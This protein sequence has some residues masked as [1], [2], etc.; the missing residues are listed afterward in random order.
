M[1][2]SKAS[3]D[4]HILTQHL[5]TFQIFTTRHEYPSQP[6]RPNSKRYCTT[7]AAGRSTTTRECEPNLDDLHRG[8]DNVMAKA[9]C[10]GRVQLGHPSLDSCDDRK[11]KYWTTVL[12]HNLLCMRGVVVETFR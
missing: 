1:Q 8:Q 12:G 4:L 10:S 5:C 7:A 9:C 3:F 2:T 11:G 6:T